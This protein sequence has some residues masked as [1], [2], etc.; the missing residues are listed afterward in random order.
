M[1]ITKLTARTEGK[2][3]AYWYFFSQIIFTQNY[4]QHRGYILVMAGKRL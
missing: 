3:N 2:Q 1:K 4:V